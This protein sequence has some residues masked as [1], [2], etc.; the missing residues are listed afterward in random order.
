MK[1]SLSV[2]TWL[3]A[4]THLLETCFV[5]WKHNWTWLSGET[6]EDLVT[7]MFSS[8]KWHERS[9]PEDTIASCLYVWKIQ[10][11]CCNW[12]STDK[13]NSV[14][15]QVLKESICIGRIRK[16]QWYRFL[17]SGHWVSV[18]HISVTYEETFFS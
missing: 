12:Y 6:L 4:T 10:N 17:W 1:A 14:Y 9:L 15:A 7:P 18:C 2:F 16:T 3:L 8:V 11:W 5:H 13:Y